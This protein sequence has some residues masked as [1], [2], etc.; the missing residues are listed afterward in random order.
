[1][2]WTNNLEKYLDVP[3][4]YGKVTQN[5]FKFILDKV[6]SLLASW[7]AKYLFLAG[8]VTLI[9]L[10]MPAIPV[11]AIETAKLPKSIYDSIDKCNRGFLWCDTEQKKKVH[12]VNWEKVYE[13]KVNRGLGIG[14]MH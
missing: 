10:V 4:I 2:P 8:S 14:S 7:K 12:L 13:P 5:T 3:T 1:M 6:Y 11:Y 9:K